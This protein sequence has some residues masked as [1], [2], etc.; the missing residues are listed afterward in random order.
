M[1]ANGTAPGDFRQ[2]F[3]GSFPRIFAWALMR[4]GNRHDAEDAVQEAYAQALRRWDRLRE[5]EA[6]DA[7]VFRVVRQQ[8]GKSARRWRRASSLDALE[9]AA[10]QANGSPEQSV[11][12]RATLAALAKLP[13]AQR[14][15]MVMYCLLGMEQQEI[16]EELGLTANAVRQRVFKARR[17]L[18]K[19]L[20]KRA[21]A[22]EDALAPATG[23]VLLTEGVLAADRTAAALRT[24]ESWLLAEIQ[25]NERGRDRIFRA[26]VARA[27]ESR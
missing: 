8:L 6:P 24:A 25:A 26:I 21:A 14:T 17:A 2:F 3:D 22:H 15:V 19:V 23:P 13:D 27:E 11:E 5:Y 10:W 18:E 7:W 12:A 1:T 16:A 4:S 20:S 9:L